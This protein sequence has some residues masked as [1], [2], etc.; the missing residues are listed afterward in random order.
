L[1][2]VNN[3]HLS[4]HV[5]GV[6]LFVNTSVIVV[7]QLFIINVVEGRSRVRVLALVGVMW[8]SFWIILAVSLALPALFA[9]V[10]ISLAMVVF[11][12]GET[13]LS[14]VGPAIVNEIAPEHLRGRYNAAQGLS[15]GLSSTIAPAIIAAFFDSGLRNWW[16]LSVALLSVSGGTFMLTLRRHLSE[17]QD[18][19]RTISDQPL[20]KD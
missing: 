16:P 6:F 5:I 3:L 17:S 18:G 7:A 19:R 4:V 15:W 9:I 8:A 2:V 10:A 11:A 1:F 20:M 12:L 13:M 14:P